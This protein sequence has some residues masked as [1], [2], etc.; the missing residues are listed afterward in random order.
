MDTLNTT[1]QALF[2]ISF[3]TGLVKYLIVEP[4]KSSLMTMEKATSELKSMLATLEKEQKIIAE[5]LIITEQAT[6]S[7]HKR[8][9]TMETIQTIRKQNGGGYDAD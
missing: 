7:A 6:K 4:L 1:A 3:L 8:L 9:D 2:I 5:R